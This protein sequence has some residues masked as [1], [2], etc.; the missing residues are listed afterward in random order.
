MTT[1][2]N[3]FITRDTQNRWDA[4]LNP[5]NP[6]DTVMAM[7]DGFT[8]HSGA[9]GDGVPMTNYTE[10]ELGLPAPEPETF[11][12]EEDNSTTVEEPIPGLKV[13]P[14][15]PRLGEL[16]KS[17]NDWITQNLGYTLIGVAVVGGIY[18]AGVRSSK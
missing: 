14:T 16:V 7:E 8:I 5:P 6:R 18:W 2:Q 13:E 10:S 15:T 17:F 12:A 9:F 4:N 11:A 3:N 1:M